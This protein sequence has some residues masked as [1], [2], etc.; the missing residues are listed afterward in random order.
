MANTLSL[1]VVKWNSTTYSPAQT[2]A[3][4]PANIKQ[5]LTQADNTVE[6][7]LYDPTKVSLNYIVCDLV[8]TSAIRDVIA[9][10]NAPKVV[11]VISI[12]T[13]TFEPIKAMVVDQL[14]VAGQYGAANPYTFMYDLGE[15]QHV[16]TKTF[17]ATFCPVAAGSNAITAVSLANKTFTVAGDQTATFVAGMAFYVEASTGGAATG[18]DKLY[19]VV[20]SAFGAATVITVNETINVN[21]VSGTIYFV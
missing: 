21:T 14:S 10:M 4:N 5:V 6:I 9:A 15:K 13:S 20:S 3:I 18:N 19:T 16:N 7:T 8:N 12:G 2:I 17:V 11:G 1:S